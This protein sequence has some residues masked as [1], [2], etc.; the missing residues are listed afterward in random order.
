MKRVTATE[1][2]KNWFRLLDDVLEGEVIVIE[3][4]GNR[5][6]IRRESEPPVEGAYS[7]SDYSHLLRVAKA[8]EADRWGWSW[9]EGDLEPDD[10]SSP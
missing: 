10:S 4:N 7:T 1:A 6:V 2:R 3:R 5:I 9:S 8:D